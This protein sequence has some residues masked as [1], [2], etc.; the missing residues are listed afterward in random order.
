MQ[1]ILY[2]AD[3]ETIEIVHSFILSFLESY[4][5]TPGFKKSDP[6]YNILAGFYVG[7]VIEMIRWQGKQKNSQ[8][9][10]SSQNYFIDLIKTILEFH[11]RYN[12]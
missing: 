2:E 11:I 6:E 10:H 4:I 5:G 7:G 12:T 3:L 1:N 8:E 9:F